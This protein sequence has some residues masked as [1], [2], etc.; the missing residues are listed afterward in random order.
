MC[1][2]ICITTPFIHRTFIII[3]IVEKKKQTRRH[4]LNTNKYSSKRL[5]VLHADDNFDNLIN[6]VF[7]YTDYLNAYVYVHTHNVLKHNV[8]IHTQHGTYIMSVAS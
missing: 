3:N 6:V 5:C 7:E 4:A 1:S 2:I 8:Q